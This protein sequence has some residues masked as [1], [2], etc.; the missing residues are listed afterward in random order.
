MCARVSPQV[1]EERQK[2]SE[3]EMEEFRQTCAGKMQK[4][5]QK[6]QRDVQLLQVQ[7]FQLQQEK[8][9]QQEELKKLLQERQRLEERCTSYEREHTQLGPRL[10]ETKWEVRSV[11]EKSSLFP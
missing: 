6:A 9:Q 8:Q 2:R 7:V 10:E 1:Y 5:S 4:A 3:L 11:D